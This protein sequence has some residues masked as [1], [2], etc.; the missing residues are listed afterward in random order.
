MSL[1]PGAGG[2]SVSRTLDS[3]SE[4]QR[5]REREGRNDGHDGESQLCSFRASLKVP[6]H[7]S[8]ALSP[9]PAVPSGNRASLH[10][11]EPRINA[12]LYSADVRLDLTFVNATGEGR[13]FEDVPALL[14]VRSLPDTTESRTRKG[15]LG[16]AAGVVGG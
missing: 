12:A 3:E 13:G 4:R 10:S 14:R 16:S 1:L 5:E 6:L 9:C 15:N 7:H 8:S 2:E 11:H